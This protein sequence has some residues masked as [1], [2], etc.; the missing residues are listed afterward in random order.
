MAIVQELNE[1][2]FIERFKEMGRGDQFSYN[3]LQAL[4]NY[5][6]DLSDDTG[7]DVKLDVI[8]ICCD[9]YE[10][11][12]QQIMDEYDLCPME[13]IENVTDPT[14]MEETAQAQHDF[15]IAYLEDNTM[16]IDC[17][18]TILYSAF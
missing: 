16:V 2:Y 7:E 17:G 5:Y 15:V 8:G 3:A 14:D 1:T 9:W 10:A 18:E 12:A 4:Y 13:A 11:T 6:D